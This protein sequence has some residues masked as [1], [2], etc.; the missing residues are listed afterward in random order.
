MNCRR[1][2]CTTLD[3]W[4]TDSLISFTELRET[5]LFSLGWINAIMSI[6]LLYIYIIPRWITKGVMTT[7][8]MFPKLLTKTCDKE[9]VNNNEN[10]NKQMKLWRNSV[11]TALHLFMVASYFKMWTTVLA[12]L[13]SKLQVLWVSHFFSEPCPDRPFCCQQ[14]CKSPVSCACHL[15]KI[16]IADGRFY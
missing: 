14:R 3:L 7:I 9:S 16:N 8:H 12:A 1:C 10:G 4:L 5:Q 13:Q 15:I 2:H 11:W 6:I